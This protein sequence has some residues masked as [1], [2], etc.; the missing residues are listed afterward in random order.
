MSVQFVSSRFT[1][2]ATALCT[3]YLIYLYQQ[4]KGKD[5]TRFRLS[6]NSVRWLSCRATLKDAFV[7]DWMEELA[8]EYGW[9]AFPHGEEFGFVHASV[10]SGWVRIG[11]KRI[12]DDRLE[13]K[14]GDSSVLEKMRDTLAQRR[15][16][17]DDLADD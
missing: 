4:E 1:V 3:A 7:L 15:L 12:V 8:S 16:N 2:E 5:V 17:D 14:R 9:I 13:L 11:T 10:V 6:R